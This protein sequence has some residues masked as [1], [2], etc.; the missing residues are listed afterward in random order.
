VGVDAGESVGGQADGRGVDESEISHVP[1]LSLPDISGLL[2][3]VHVIAS[4]THSV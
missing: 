1:S 3:C 2:R 4:G